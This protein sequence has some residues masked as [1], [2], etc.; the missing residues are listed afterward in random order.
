MGC[1]CPRA[2][3][4]IK[5]PEQN[6]LSLKVD[7]LGVDAYKIAQDESMNVILRKK[8]SSTQMLSIPH[9]AGSKFGVTGLVFFDTARAFYM[10]NVNHALAD[11]A[12]V[13]F[14]TGLLKGARVWRQAF[15]QC[16]R[17]LD[18][19]GFCLSAA[20]PVYRGG[21]RPGQAGG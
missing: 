17:G 12:A 14:N 6:F 15:I 13:T 10:F 21:D 9:I 8:D 11:Q 18:C 7:V 4:L 19:G 2:G 16:I 5:N 1:A 3:A 20:E